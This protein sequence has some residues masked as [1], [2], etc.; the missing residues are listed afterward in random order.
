M[1]VGLLPHPFTE[2]LAILPDAVKYTFA[3]S[4]AMLP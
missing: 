4:A 3:L 2:H 1:V